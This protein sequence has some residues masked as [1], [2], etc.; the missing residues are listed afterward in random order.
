MLK[1]LNFSPYCMLV[2]S[3]CQTL[4]L[5]AQSCVNFSSHTASDIHY[6]LSLP[7]RTK[8]Y[9]A[10]VCNHWHPFFSKKPSNPFAA[11][12]WIN[13]L[14]PRSGAHPFHSYYSSIS[15]QAV[16]HLARAAAIR[17]EA[18]FAL[19]LSHARRRLWI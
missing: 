4:A 13:S 19:H 10:T 5:E 7:Y 2:A 14:R 8:V 11:L 3:P 9:F 12:G 17:A 16:F 15:P 1:I 18:R 6:S